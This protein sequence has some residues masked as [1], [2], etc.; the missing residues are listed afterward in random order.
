M[1]NDESLE[2]VPWQSEHIYRREINALYNYLDMPQAE[3]DH[4][5]ARAR[6]GDRAAREAMLYALLKMVVVYATRMRRVRANLSFLDLVSIGNVTLV[7]YFA[8]ALTKENPWAYLLKCARLRIVEAFSGHVEQCITT[9]RTPG[10]EPYI[11]IPLHPGLNEIEFDLPEPAPPIEEDYGPLYAAI[12]A[13]PERTTRGE[14]QRELVLRLYGLAG[15]GAE[16]MAEV[17]GVQIARGEQRYHALKHRRHRALAKLQAHLEQHAPEFARRH[18][19][20][21]APVR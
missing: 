3:R 12:A 4:L 2:R 11:M 7:E 10:V 6:Q 13:L 9:P 18:R 16:S 5:V 8:E 15:F 14:V 19:A 1:E 17:A 21:D 20:A